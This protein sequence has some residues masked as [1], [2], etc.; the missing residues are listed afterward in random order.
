MEKK[1]KIG[2]K[3]KKIKN[4]KIFLIKKKNIYI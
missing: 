2:M 3:E 4:N 1:K